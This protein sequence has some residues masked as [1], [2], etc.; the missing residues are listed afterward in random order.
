MSR[1]EVRRSSGSGSSPC[2]ARSQPSTG[3]HLP[4]FDLA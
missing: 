4:V 1:D 3:T 2:S